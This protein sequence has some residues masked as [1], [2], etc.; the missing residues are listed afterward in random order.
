MIKN[1]INKTVINY[2]KKLYYD[3]KNLLNEDNYEN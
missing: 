3:E 1:N 2:D